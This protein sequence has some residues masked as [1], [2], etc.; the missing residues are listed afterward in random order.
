MELLEN[1]GY[2]PSIARSRNLSGPK[3]DNRCSLLINSE[4]DTLWIIPFSRW[5]IRK[6]KLE[7]LQF[8]LEDS[9]GEIIAEC[10]LYGVDKRSF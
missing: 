10:N 8:R 4:I 6:S 2:C 1:H 3:Q 9:N 5:L 7:A